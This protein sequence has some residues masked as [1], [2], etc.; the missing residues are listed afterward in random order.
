MVRAQFLCGLARQ[1]NSNR[2]FPNRTTSWLVAHTMIFRL[3][4]KGKF[5]AYVATVTFDQ[6]GPKL[7]S[8]MVY[9]L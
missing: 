2:K 3:F 4:M 1:H 7:N 5:D 8:C 9:C 6:K